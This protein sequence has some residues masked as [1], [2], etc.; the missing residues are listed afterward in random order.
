MSCGLISGERSTRWAYVVLAVFAVLLV[1]MFVIADRL[2]PAGRH[3]AKVAGLIRQLT[4]EFLT[5]CS[6][7]TIST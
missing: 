1:A 4:L 2:A 6:S 5:R 3:V 7:I